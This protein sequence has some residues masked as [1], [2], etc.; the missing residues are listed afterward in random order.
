MTELL[1]L[2]PLALG[3]FDAV[4][5]G[6]KLLVTPLTTTPPPLGASDTVAPLTV[7][8]GAPGAKV[9][10][11]YWNTPDGPGVNVAP[12]TVN[13]EAGPGELGGLG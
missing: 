4:P 6:L 11:E 2:A 12:P 10:E 13:G 8:A 9:M 7:V 5:V 1:P 3:R